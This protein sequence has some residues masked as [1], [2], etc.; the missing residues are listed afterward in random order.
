MLAA[1]NKKKEKRT[2][3][4]GTPLSAL[5]RR[6]Q[7]AVRETKVGFTGSWSCLSQRHRL[8]CA[9]FSQAA[10]G[11]VSVWQSW[12]KRT[13]RR[14]TTTTTKAERIYRV[15][16]KIFFPLVGAQTPAARSRPF[17]CEVDI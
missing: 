4:L 8:G 14:S 12:K 10:R 2:S 1:G 5:S 11:N 15:F 9:T 17:F 6:Q 13:T 16:G 3:P 7:L